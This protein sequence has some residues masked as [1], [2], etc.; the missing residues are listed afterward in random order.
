MCNRHYLNYGGEEFLVALIN[1]WI[2]G[3]CLVAERIRI[4]VKMAGRNLSA[5]ARNEPLKKTLALSTTRRDPTNQNR[6]G[7]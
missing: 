4:S 3:A 6:Y 5:S 7:R 1:T 2:E